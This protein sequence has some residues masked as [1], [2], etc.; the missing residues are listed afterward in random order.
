[1]HAATPASWMN[2]PIMIAASC[3][4]VCKCLL[5]ALLR[6]HRCRPGTPPCRPLQRLTHA[7]TPAGGSVKRVPD[8]HS[9][10]AGSYRSGRLGSSPLVACAPLLAPRVA[11]LAVR[12]DVDG[13]ALQR[14]ADVHRNLARLDLLGLRD[15]Q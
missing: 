5:S 14:R 7:L 11:L 4:V 6:L 9:E 3:L 8:P 10:A 12:G 1:M 13:L 15:L 2:N